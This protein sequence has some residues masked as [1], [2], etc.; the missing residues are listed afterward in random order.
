MIRITRVRRFATAS[1]GLVALTALATA[2]TPA[3]EPAATTRVT[4]LAPDCD[5]CT[6]GLINARWDEEV[7][8]S[9]RRTVRDGKVTFRV[10]TAMTHGMSVAIR[11]PWEGGT[12]YVTHVAF[13]YAGQE[14]GDEVTFAEA[15]HAGKASACWA[16]TTA[17][18]TTIS[19]A[20][21]HVTVPGY[22]GENTPAAL[23]YTSI[24]QD[25]MVPMRKTFRG[26]VG[27]QDV[28]FCGRR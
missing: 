17:D 12:G 25:A 23:V 8:E 28:N 11:A 3:A 18:S 24:T 2:P 9:P 13:K 5:G 10:P 22:D 26:I 19:L 14:P 4:F 21:R 27:S 15:R 16:G 6:L 1:I 20:T 7:W